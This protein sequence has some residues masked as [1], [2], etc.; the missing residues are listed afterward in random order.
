MRELLLCLLEGLGLG[1][2]LVLV[3]AVGI[4]RVRVVF[5]GI[6]ARVGR[7]LLRLRLQE[8]EQVSD[9]DG[10]D[11][12]KAPIKQK[13]RKQKSPP[14]QKQIFVKYKKKSA[15]RSALFFL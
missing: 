1:A 10:I 14:R 5:A 11:I 9:S 13:R 8:E 12:P 2:L 3:C 15:E 4:R 7:S 6:H